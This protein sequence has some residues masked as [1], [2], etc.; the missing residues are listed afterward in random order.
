MMNR[1]SLKTFILDVE[2]AN[3]PNS[4][5]QEEVLTLITDKVK[6]DASALKLYK[7]FLL[8]KGIQ[9]RYFSWNNLQELLDESVDEK[10][11]RFEHEAVRLSVEA[12]QKLL[13]KLN[14][15]PGDINALFVSTCTGYLCP[16]LSTYISQQL[17][18][19]ENIY[20]LDL[21]GLGCTG[22]LPG[23]R[24][25]DDYLNRYPDSNV[26]V[27]AVEICSAAIHWAEKPE[28]ILSNS[29]FSDGA[30]A[31]LLTNKP[32]TS[33]LQIQN[34][35]SVLWPE[36]RD[37]LRFKYLD[38]RL[39]N[40]ISPKV[41]DIASRA[42]RALYKKPSADPTY[43]AFHSGGRKVLDAI[44]ESLHLSDDDMSPSREILRDYGNMSSPS[45]LFALK[46][47]LRKELEDKDS[48]V[49][50]SFGAGF[51]ASMLQAQWRSTV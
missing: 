40:V 34:I 17:G 23:L 30:A 9:R 42:I 10:I 33:G 41:C 20:T 14:Y 39:C 8:D 32:K 45:V 5:T 18:L 49:C 29:I 36:Y 24:S 3:P 19:S 28:L 15:K 43:Y 37:E 50:F 48:V 27:V 25:A 44:Q 35:S 31:V 21:V 47:I 13:E 16:G 51:L 6:P 7:R 26:L 22:A 2:T 12:V 46:T 38:A 11:K 4:L 1:L